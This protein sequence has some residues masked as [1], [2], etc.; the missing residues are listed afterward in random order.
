MDSPTSSAPSYKRS[1]RIR[2]PASW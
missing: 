2:V 1:T